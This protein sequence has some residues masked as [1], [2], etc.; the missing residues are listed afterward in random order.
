MNDEER[1]KKARDNANNAQ[2]VSALANYGSNSAN[3]Y[4]KVIGTGIRAA[5]KLS[6]GE[7]SKKL[8][9]F[10]S[11]VNKHSGLKGKIAQAA[12]NKLGESGTTDRI[13]QALN[14]K[15][16]SSSNSLNKSS[17]KAKGNSPSSNSGFNSLFSDTKKK[18]TEESTSDGG[19]TNLKTS[20]K[21]VRYGMIAMIPISILVVIM[22]LFTSASQIYINVIGLAHADSV[23]N[24]EASKTIDKK[25]SENSS[26]LER[27]IDDSNA[28][29]AAYNY[30]DS[31][32]KFR[33]AKLEEYNLVEVSF[34]ITKYLK[35]K[36]SDVTLEDLED[37]YPEVIRYSK[38]NEEHKD[39][40]YAFFYKLY[41]VYKNY[42]EQYDVQLDMPLIMSTLYIQSSDKVLVFSSN[43]SSEDRNLNKDAMEK[44]AKENFTYDKDWG[45]YITTETN[46]EH[47]I[48]V[49][50]QH[51]VSC[52]DDGK[53]KIDQEK[54]REFLKEFIEKKYLLEDKLP[55]S[56]NNI[57]FTNTH[58]SIPATSFKK[59]DLTEAQISAIAN[60]CYSKS[61]SPEDAAMISSL[62]ANNYEKLPDSSTYKSDYETPALGFYNYV[63]SGKV[64]GN[65]EEDMEKGTAPSRIV[66]SV[67]DVLV[68]GK[69]TLPKYVDEPSCWGCNNNTCNNGKKGNICSVNNDGK[70][71]N[72]NSFSSYLSNISK[73]KTRYM[74]DG[75]NP[76]TFYSLS[77][78]GNIVFGYSSEKYKQ[79]V[80]ECHYDFN[81]S[82]FK[83]CGNI[84]LSS[85]S[86]SNPSP[87]P[88]P[89]PSSN[90]KLNDKS[91][92]NFVN[93]FLKWLIGIADD[94][95]HGYDQRERSGPDYDCSS[96]VYFGL[97]NNGFTTQQLN[98]YAFSTYTMP[99]LLKG[100]G[101]KEIPFNTLVPDGITTTNLQPGDILLRDGHTEVYVG[102][103]M[104]VGAH[105]SEYN[106]PVDGCKYAKQK[107]DQTGEEISVKN[108][109]RGTRKWEY[110]YRYAGE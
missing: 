109:I 87:T 100:S 38:E 56:S 88:T 73:I 64:F 86:S 75:N 27:E 49:L 81:T 47:D 72:V 43:L 14:A 17:M 92:S 61:S 29:E 8:G 6:G 9:E 5:D 30:D 79:D 2:A 39:T 12:I 89:N 33:K 16:A 60:L 63:V 69:R 71:I 77:K 7:A 19:L 70:D 62:L 101:F 53:C 57:V 78:K 22:C 50:A 34:R 68:L 66:E 31:Y 85:D 24:P 10:V 21:V 41:Y 59:Y 58:V 42:Y 37:F 11:T 102:D 52:T 20:F 98:T 28:D 3:P 107:G 76:Y 65:T 105:C 48:E 95:A 54:Y 18:E 94:P 82:E 96:L 104:A 4:A 110:V 99:E 90:I 83:N 40:I 55:L 103:G 106:D 46:S 1:L 97:I 36:N 45:N 44:R 35:R 13:N 93:G 91:N 26:S 23:S 80:G 67:K 32:L 25:L 84:S 51:M 74:N 108:A 15:N